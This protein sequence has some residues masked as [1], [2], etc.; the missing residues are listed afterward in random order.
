MPPV[1]WQD[2]VTPVI[3]QARLDSDCSGCSQESLKGHVDS[4]QAPTGACIA[5]RLQTATQQDKTSRTFRSASSRREAPERP[6]R[7][8]W[9]ACGQPGRHQGGTRNPDLGAPGRQERTYWTAW[10]APGQERIKWTAW[11]APGRHQE[12]I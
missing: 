11:D 9:T 5:G 3:C 8:I 1:I 12:V 10:E 7:T 2:R 6:E 4:P